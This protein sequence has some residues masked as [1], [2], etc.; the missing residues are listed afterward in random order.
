M[1]RPPYKALLISVISWSLLTFHSQVVFAAATESKGTVTTDSKGVI[2]STKSINF[3]K[4]GDSDMLTSLT[5]IAG[6]YIAGRMYQTY[7]PVSLDVQIAAAGGVAFIAGE[8]MS[9]M[10]F[11]GKM[12]AMTVQVE[13]K[14]DGSV[15]EE[16]I[17]RLQDL[18]K[19]YEEA[20]GA[21]K[22]KKTMQLA[23]AAAF[24]AAALT[25]AYLATTEEAQNAA[26]MMSV[27]GGKAELASCMSA[28][29]TGVGASEATACGVC[30]G[31]L[32]AWGSGLLKYI[33]L[34][35]AQGPTVEKTAETKTLEATLVSPTGFCTQST[36]AT[37]QIIGKSIAST[38]IPAV[39]R[40]VINEQ[41]GKGVG[42]TS[43]NPKTINKYLGLPDSGAIASH[44]IKPNIF[45]NYLERSLSLFFPTAKAS[46]LPML[47]LTAGVGLAFTGILG[48]LGVTVDTFM[49]VPTNRAIVFGSLAGLSFMASRS[50][51]KMM[52]NMD[53]NI[54]K[55]DAILADLSKNAKGIKAQNLSSQSVSI[56]TINPA[57]KTMQPY[58]ETGTSKSPCMA[59]N[60]S[61]NC[62][63]L[64]D[65]LSSMPGY[66]ALPDSFKNIASQS[67]SLGD[68]LSGSTG[69][70]GSAL[71][72]AESLGNKQAAIA[73]A[74]KNQEA[75]LSKITKGKYNSDLGKEKFQE[76]ANAAI[77]KAL[78]K[79][80]MNATGFMASIG[81]A[82]ID[83]SLKPAAGSED[84]KKESFGGTTVDM[85]AGKGSGEA[86]DD[87]MKVEFK[88]GDGSAVA[89]GVPQV[90]GG[91]EPEYDVK[92][93]EIN[94]KNGP[95]I[96][97]VISRRYLKSGYPKLLEEVAVEKN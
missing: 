92:T 53:E 93:D 13:K 28:G 91:S 33:G 82:P 83:S 12:A 30:D 69:I 17:Q 16:Q 1:L 67:V 29:A 23:A 88:E 66:A 14:S 81:S 19:S 40:M 2:T 15:N 36:G 10:K 51:G 52:D 58:T 26:C 35:Q 42:G 32:I 57:L 31:E 21:T 68:S 71:A 43:F 47:G 25:A 62:A 72:S 61:E 41:V 49:Y 80:G 44:T 97:E 65:K 87:S 27:K 5:M 9:N 60:S 59:G 22:T 70:S 38:C 90:S 73:K 63:S 20:K 78:Q 7:T 55:I 95:S 24:G 56:K 54:K 45:E 86:P 76:R 3:D 39:K 64:S 18:R 46:W 84:L 74:L 6:G 37:A 89:L 94:G 4:V 85:S 79:H 75:Q 77:R 8:I 11:K 34:R 50:S 48:T 96:F